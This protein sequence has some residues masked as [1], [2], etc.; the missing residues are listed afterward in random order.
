MDLET[1]VLYSELNASAPL[2]LTFVHP[3]LFYTSGLL[4]LLIYLLQ[5]SLLSSLNH[6]VAYQK[7]VS[8]AYSI[9]ISEFSYIFQFANIGGLHAF[10]AALLSRSI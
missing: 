7:V 6:N 10:V 1:D 5:D 3:E 8:A 9:N 4:L 2:L